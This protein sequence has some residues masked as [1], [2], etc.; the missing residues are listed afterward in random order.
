[1][2]SFKICLLVFITTT[3]MIWVNQEFYKRDCKIQEI[4]K[5]SCINYLALRQAGLL[6]SWE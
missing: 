6:E 2:N 4:E 5:R 3:L 1:M